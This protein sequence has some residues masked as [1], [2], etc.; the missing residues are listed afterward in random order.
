MFSVLYRDY[1]FFNTLCE[2]A[3]YENLAYLH[4]SVDFD[5]LSFKP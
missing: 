5:T 3:L 1:Y 4:E 2:S